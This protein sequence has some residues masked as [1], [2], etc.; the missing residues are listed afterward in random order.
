M[1]TETRQILHTIASASAP[2]MHTE[3]RQILHTI[4]SASAPAMHTVN[5]FV[6]SEKCT[7]LIIFQILD[8]QAGLNDK[9]R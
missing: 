3:T 6:N 2:A 4:A 9:R 7:R 1:H 8:Q 5:T